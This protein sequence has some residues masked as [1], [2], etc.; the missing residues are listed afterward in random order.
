MLQVRELDK[1]FGGLAALDRIDMEIRKSEI[2]GIIGP[3]GAGKTTLFNVISGFFPPT[4]G[5]VIFQGQNITGLRADEIAQR[6]ISRT[7]QAATLFMSVS[8]LE[9]VFI[10]CHKWYQTNIWKRLFRLPS[11]L[12][13]E[14]ALREKA[15]EI[16]EFMGLDSI[17]D[18]VAKNLPHG[19]QKILSVCIALA[20]Q[21]KLLLLDE[22]VTGMNP[23]EV[24]LMIDLILR[25]RDSGVTIAIVEHNMKTVLDL[26]DRLVVL[27]YGQKIAEGLPEKILENQE[28]I[29]AYLGEEETQ[30]D[31]ARD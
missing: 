6:G 12:R 10:G 31:A 25:I 24:R 21:P 13:E 5:Q 4:S 1:H 14:T 9:N 18:E 26:C 23:T 28:V 17:R 3:N 27:N 16:I 8:V 29:E 15:R 11:A 2:L 20:T 30:G 22:P 7:F 19:H